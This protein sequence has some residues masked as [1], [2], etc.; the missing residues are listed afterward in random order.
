[1]PATPRRLTAL[2]ILAATSSALASCGDLDQA[3]AAGATPGDLVASLADQLAGTP[4]LTYTA[5]YRLPGGETARATRT[6][7]PARAAY[8]FTGGRLIRTEA[9]LTRCDPKTCTTTDPTPTDGLPPTSGMV[10]PEAVLALMETAA[11]DPG[12]EVTQEDTTRAGR[13]ATCLTVRGLESFDTCVTVEG[14]LAGFTGSIEGTPVEMV[15]VDY[16]DEVEELDFMPPP[17]A[18]LIDKRNK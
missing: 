11:I 16:A 4:R 15:L 7:D 18:H 12:V 14:A 3:S 2:L 8:V 1:M 13:N 17:S 6:A 9:A 5:T 10:T